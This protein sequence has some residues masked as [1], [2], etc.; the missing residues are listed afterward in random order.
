MQL[1]ELV[2]VEC[3]STW[4][5]LVSDFTLKSLQS[6]KVNGN[7]RFFWKSDAWSFIL[8]FSALRK[9][10]KLYKNVWISFQWTSSSIY[11]LLGLFSKMI[12]TLPYSKESAEKLHLNEFVPKILEGFI[13]SRFDSIQVK[14][15]CF[16]QLSIHL[17]LISSVTKYH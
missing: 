11:Y 12:T 6:W 14:K 4:M 7:F 5:N 13:S 16:E 3:F 15:F 9:Q 1:S 2:S 10:C 17:F 8:S